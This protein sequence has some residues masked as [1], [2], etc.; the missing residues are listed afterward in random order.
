MTQAPHPTRAELRL[1]RV[2]WAEGPLTVR[3]VQQALNETRAAGYTTVLK[4]LQIMADKG[5]VVRDDSVRPQIYRARHRQERT[6]KQLLQ[7]LVE[8]AYAG[9]VKA[10]VLHAVG[11]RN[12]SRE[13]LDALEELLDRFERG[14]K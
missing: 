14:R 12:P 3:A 1:L 5:L 11:T 7:H 9:S 8:S 10:L 4:T 6:Q 2:L 13:D